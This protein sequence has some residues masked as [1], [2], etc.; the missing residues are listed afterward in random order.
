VV[1]YFK[2]LLPDRYLVLLLLLLAFRLPYW[3]QGFP[4]LKAGLNW[5]LL[6][7]RLGEGWLLYRD[8]WDD[9]AP[10][11]A[12]VYLGIDLLFGR[13]ATAYY[14]IAAL[15]VLMQ[16]F[17]LLFLTRKP[18][19]SEASLFPALIY[20]VA[21]HWFFDFYTLSPVLL[22]LSFLIPTLGQVLNHLEKPIS[23]AELFTTGFL[24]GLATLCYAPVLALFICIC[25]GF[26]TL[27][28][29]T[30]R[31]VFL[32]FVG[33]CLLIG[34]CIGAFFLMD[35]Q[36]EFYYCYLLS[37]TPLKLESIRFSTPFVVTL[38]LVVFLGLTLLRSFVR[39]QRL[40]NYQLRSM[41]FM[42]F[43][44]VAALGSIQLSRNLY[45]YQFLMLL[46][47]VAFFGTHSFLSI[48]KKWWVADLSLVFFFMLVL[49]VNLYTRIDV[50]VPGSLWDA[51]YLTVEPSSV[52]E[53]R[54]QKV[55]VLSGSISPYQHNAMATPYL[56]PYLA[57][58]DLGGLDTYTAVVRVYSN[59]NKD[60]PDYLID[61]ENLLKPVFFRI[62]LLAGMYCIHPYYKGVYIR[63]SVKE[64]LF[65]RS[66]ASNTIP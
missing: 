37:L 33:Y 65:S 49:G 55:L 60:L 39:N 17:Q 28:S 42:F 62:P 5:M 18:L 2:K 58:R 4:L 51:R 38:P 27:G 8:V 23:D 21:A 6:G 48:R 66:A 1:Q 22:S 46:P 45:P 11:S 53:I 3:W 44:S 63:K 16:S 30:F 9:T 7:E 25:F 59:F 31:Q 24:A 56:K 41:Q 20:L 12:L 26:L 19:Y 14:W 64:Q 54:N 15:L 29:T 10:L 13:S 36:E 34:L 40:L 32:L 50:S 47:A 52:P 35:V 57:E 61:P 43:W